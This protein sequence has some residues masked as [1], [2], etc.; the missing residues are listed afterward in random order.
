MSGDCDGAVHPPP[1]MAGAPPAQLGKIFMQR[2]GKK[3]KDI[4]RTIDMDEMYPEDLLIT[5]TSGGAG[6]GNPLNRDPDRVRLNVRDGFLSMKRAKDVYGVVLTQ[7][8]K[9][10]PETIEVD[11]EATKKLRKK[12]KQ[13]QGSQGSKTRRTIKG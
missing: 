12:M 3:K 7:K 4:F 11:Y 8:K 5:T 1:G 2:A 10:N 6:W 9:G 13:E